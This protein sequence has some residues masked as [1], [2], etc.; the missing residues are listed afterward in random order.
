MSKESE[1]IRNQLPKRK[2]YRKAYKHTVNGRINNL[3]YRRKPEIK[4]KYEE[5][6][7]KVRYGIT[8]AEYWDL[9]A[10]QNGV[11]AI[12]GNPNGKKLHVDHDHKTNKVRGLLCGNCNKGIGLFKDDI[13]LLDKAIKYLNGQIHKNDST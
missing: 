2:A 7:L 10:E 3:K 5:Y 9:V 11:C 12:C 13:T 8:T 1:R 6:R 4:A